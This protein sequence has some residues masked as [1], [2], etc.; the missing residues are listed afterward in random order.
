MLTPVQRDEKYRVDEDRQC[1]AVL[2][3]T[4]LDYNGYKF[5]DDTMAALN[6]IHPMMASLTCGEVRAAIDLLFGHSVTI[7]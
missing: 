1:I 4:L 2:G 3:E 7:R 6:A 5:R